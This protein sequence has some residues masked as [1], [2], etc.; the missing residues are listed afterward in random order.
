MNLNYW[1]WGTAAV[2]FLVSYAV[3]SPEEPVLLAAL[4]LLSLLLSGWSGRWLKKTV[5]KPVILFDLHGV[6]IDGDMQVENLKEVPG[7]RDLIRRLRGNYFVAALTNFS[8]ELIRFYDKRFGLMG[9]FDAF[10]Y[11]GQYGIRKPDARIFGIVVKGIGV[12]PSDIVFIDDVGENV[13]AAKKAG[14]RAI[15]F[16][17]PAQARAALHELGVSV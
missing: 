13:A 5:R 3:L 11:S 9:E 15:L 7:T 14:L 10:F 1:R 6:L 16:Q 12:R 2:V 17:S 8:P 4:A